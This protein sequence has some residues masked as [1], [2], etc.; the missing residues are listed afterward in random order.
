LEVGQYYMRM[1]RLM[2]DGPSRIDDAKP[3][4]AVPFLHLGEAQEKKFPKPWQIVEIPNDLCR[5]ETLAP[6]RRFLRPTDSEQ[7][8]HTDFV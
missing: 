7:A 6:T 5:D 4:Y 8:G 3:G 2:R 1:E